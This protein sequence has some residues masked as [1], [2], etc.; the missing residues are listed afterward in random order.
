MPPP[1][2]RPGKNIRS[3]LFFPTGP[4]WLAG[5]P[6]ALNGPRPRTWPKVCLLSGTKPCKKCSKSGLACGSL[7]PGLTSPTP[8][9]G[10]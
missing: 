1:P 3:W 10:M 2:S 6:R 5:F 7:R 9:T 8:W 4:V